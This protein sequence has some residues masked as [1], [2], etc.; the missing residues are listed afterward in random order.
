MCSGLLAHFVLG[1]SPP[2]TGAAGGA[3]AIAYVLKQIFH[4][5]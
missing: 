2:A 3:G 4:S 1:V 5:I